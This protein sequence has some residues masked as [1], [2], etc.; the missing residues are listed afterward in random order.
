MESTMANL[1]LKPRNYI[2]KT[3]EDIIY[4]LKQAVSDRSS[5]EYTELISNLVKMF[6]DSDVNKDGTVDRS[7]FSFLID[8]AA[9]TPRMFGFAPPDDVMYSTDA[10]KAAARGKMFDTLANSD[11]VTLNAWIKFA[12]EHIAKKVATMDAHPSLETPHKKEFSAF[13]K[14]AHVSGTPEKLDLYWYL[15]QIFLA[16]CEK[17]GTVSKAGFT[18]MVDKASAIPRRHGT[19]AKVPSADMFDKVAEG[20]EYVSWDQWLAFGLSNIFKI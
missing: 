16:H 3:K 15:L 7:E 13:V 9:F 2:N 11:G 10:Q 4:F 8:S 12:I 17:S 19:L 14:N 20:G 18:I 6:V 5:P 1:D